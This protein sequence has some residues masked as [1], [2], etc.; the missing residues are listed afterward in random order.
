[1]IKRSECRC[2]CHT[3]ANILGLIDVPMHVMPCCEEDY[4]MNKVSEVSAQ[5][6][7]NEE[8]HDRIWNAAIERAAM[9]AEKYE[10]YGAAYE[11]RLE[12]KK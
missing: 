7:R 8:E 12:L 10:S 6:K 9:I 11:I 1:M 3:D 4:E 2:L 5:V